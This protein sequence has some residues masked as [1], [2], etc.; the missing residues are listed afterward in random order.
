MFAHK[1]CV[2]ARYFVVGVVPYAGPN[3]TSNM[4]CIVYAPEVKL[5]LYSTRARRNTIS[6]PKQWNIS[7]RFLLMRLATC[8]AMSFTKSFTQITNAFTNS[9]KTAF[10]CEPSHYCASGPH[11]RKTNQVFY[12]A[13]MVILNHLRMTRTAR[14]ITFGR[15]IARGRQYLSR[16]Y[17]NYYKRQSGNRHC[18]EQKAVLS[19]TSTTL[20]N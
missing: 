13:P 3:N 12:F 6:P 10:F 20:L 9:G 19:S 1:I 17:A 4:K 18:G 7:I 2:A 5:R 15:V 14:V 16:G 11:E 8:R